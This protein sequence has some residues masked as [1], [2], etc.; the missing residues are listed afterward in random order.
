MANI[1]F[2]IPSVLNQGAGE[3]KTEISAESL[4]DAFAKISDVMGDDFKRKVLE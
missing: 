2:T 1:I 4:S 3:K